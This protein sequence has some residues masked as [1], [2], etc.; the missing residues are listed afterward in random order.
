MDIARSGD[1]LIRYCQNALIKLLI[2][3]IV[4]KKHVSKSDTLSVAYCIFTVPCS[5][6]IKASVT[7]VLWVVGLSVL[8]FSS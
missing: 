1:R 6:A 2:T 8:I 5:I 4:K 7:A 3:C